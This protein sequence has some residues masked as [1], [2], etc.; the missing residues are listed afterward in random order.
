[1]VSS[2]AAVAQ[3][4]GSARINLP[5]GGDPIVE[6]LSSVPPQATEADLTPEQASRRFLGDYFGVWSASNL[7]AMAF[8]DGAYAALVDFYGKPTQRQVIIDAK[9]KYVER[10]PER[11]YLV[12]P[13]RLRLGCDAGSAMCLITDVVDWDCR[14]VARGAHSVGV[15]D[16]TLRVAFVAPGA[17]KIVL[18]AGS[19]IARSA[20]P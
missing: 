17:G 5:A 18:E 10:W 2:A 12:R 7:A 15:A 4:A 6:V 3:G 9:R 19:V 1:M 14:S 16:F 20:S 11:S 13:G 8:V